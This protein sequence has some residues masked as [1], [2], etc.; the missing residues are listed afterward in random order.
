VWIV[1]MDGDHDL[2]AA[3]ELGQ[4]FDAGRRWWST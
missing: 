3:P 2:S 1:V 4:A